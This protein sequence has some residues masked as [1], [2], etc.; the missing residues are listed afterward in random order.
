MTQTMNRTIQVGIYSFGVKENPNQGSEVHYVW[1]ATKYRD[2]RGS[3]T[4]TRNC[5][6]GLDKRVQAWVKQDARYAAIMDSVTILVMDA[7]AQ[8]ATWIS[9]GFADHHG[10]W[11]S[12][13]LAELAA[14]HLEVQGEQYNVQLIHKGL[15]AYNAYNVH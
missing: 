6:N 5:V 4:L 9:V 11:T 13:A 8:Q 1:D 14:K 3:K 7:Y 10:Y 12:V 15:T 2:A